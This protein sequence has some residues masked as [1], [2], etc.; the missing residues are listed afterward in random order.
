MSATVV[1][2]GGNFIYVVANVETVCWAPVRLSKVDLQNELYLQKVRRAFQRR[3]RADQHRG[4]L[5]AE[6]LDKESE[7]LDRDP[8]VLEAAV[9]RIQRRWRSFQAAI[10][11]ADVA[12]EVMEVRRLSRSSS[13]DSASAFSR[14]SKGGDGGGG[15]KTAAASTSTAEDRPRA[16]P[17][18]EAWWQGQWRRWTAAVKMGPKQGGGAADQGNGVPT[19]LASASRPARRASSLAIHDAAELDCGEFVADED[20]D[21]DDLTSPKKR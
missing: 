11:F 4:E 17:R 21:L 19:T 2:I 15:T 18:R 6:R 3:I 5:K 12:C 14:R 8:A 10:K 7:R 20:V 9:V 13:A 1:M 16:K